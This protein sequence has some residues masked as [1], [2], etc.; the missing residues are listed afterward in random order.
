M[1]R[2]NI[3]VQTENLVIYT[4]FYLWEKLLTDI[5]P[6]ELNV[7]TYVYP[8]QEDLIYLGRG[9]KGMTN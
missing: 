4:R 9:I 1:L 5:K 6:H 3:E 2:L 8:H 7:K